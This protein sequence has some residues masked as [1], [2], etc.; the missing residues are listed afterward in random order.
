MD[1]VKERLIYFLKKS[2]E[3]FSNGQILSGHVGRGQFGRHT[4]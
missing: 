2:Y 1:I 3:V 4:N